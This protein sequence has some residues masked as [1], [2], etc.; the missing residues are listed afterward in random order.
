MYLLIP[1]TIYVIEKQVICIIL[2][3]IMCYIDI[4]NNIC[5][6]PKSNNSTI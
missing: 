1:I 3:Y 5:K 6:Q 4:Q 2:Y